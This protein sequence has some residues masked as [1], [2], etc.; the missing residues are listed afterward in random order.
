MASEDK[1]NIKTSTSVKDGEA[2]HEKNKPL[3][4][5]RLFSQVNIN[6]PLPRELALILPSLSVN[7]TSEQAVTNDDAIDSTANVMANVSSQKTSQQ[8]EQNS[9][10]ENV[11]VQFETKAHTPTDESTDNRSEN[12][13]TTARSSHYLS[14][15]LHPI[16]NH[17][18]APVNPLERPKT[19]SFT[20]EKTHQYGTHPNPGSHWP[21]KLIPETE[22]ARDKTNGDEKSPAEHS[23]GKGKSRPTGSHQESKK[24]DVDKPVTEP[25]L[26]LTDPKTSEKSHE[27]QTQP[28]PTTTYID[29]TIKGKFGSL[30]ID[31]SGKYTFTL[32]PKSPAYI[33]LQ[34]QEP[35]T[36][37]FT[38]HLSNGSTTV[39][40]I[41][42][43]GKQDAP[44]I[45][46]DLQGLVREDHHVN[47]AGLI[48][49]SGKIDVVD[50]DHSESSVQAETIQG[51][52]GTLTINSKGQWQYQVDN[53]QSNIQALTQSTA[54]HETFTIH[55]KDGTPQVLNMTIGGEDDNAII[56]GVDN[57]A[58][59]EDQTTHCQGQLLVTDADLGE[60]HFQGSQ[61]IGVLG[62]LT[63]TK[64]GAWRYDLDN[65]NPKVQALGQG[66]TATDTITVTSADG[67]QHQITITV[68]GTN[69]SAVITG[70]YSGTVTEESQLQTSGT[71]TVTDVD[72]G[73]AHFSNTDVVGSLGTL[74]LQNNGA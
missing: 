21:D 9:A 43:Q 42:V 55:T 26:P 34:K 18:A 60:D 3:K 25:K 28:N 17:I 45:S 53:S 65:A 13:G 32:D 62:T 7:A 66:A 24:H 51:Q 1:K 27:H 19:P 6:V 46:G 10:S 58:V 47:S 63:I 5:V 11:S 52:F 68:N 38:L 37:T 20:G 71:L 23:Q 2:T 22:H 29:E 40:H 70:T 36:D 49:T 64:D 8:N 67:T 54:L 61:V 31:T 14:T 59:N 72:T 30:H 44:S 73:E 16:V 33:L 41:P 69:D 50:P 74:H 56:S 57:G 12:H 39:I 35:G 48:S 4:K 15:K